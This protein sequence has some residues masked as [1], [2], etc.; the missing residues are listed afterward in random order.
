MG[1]LCM[2]SKPDDAARTSIADSPR[3]PNWAA[4][5]IGGMTLFE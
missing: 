5:W 4:F 2:A 1:S 3:K